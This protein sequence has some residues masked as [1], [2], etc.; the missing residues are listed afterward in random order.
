MIADR[1]LRLIS[2]DLRWL[3]HYQHFVA[4]SL[5]NGESVR[6][7][8]ESHFNVVG[9]RSVSFRSSARRVWGV[10]LHRWLRAENTLRINIFNCVIG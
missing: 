7:R 1:L 2:H 6:H 9:G 10:E 8:A 5:L 4:C 3:A